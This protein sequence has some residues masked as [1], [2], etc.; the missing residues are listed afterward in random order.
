MDTDRI[1]PN[2]DEEVQAA[3]IRRVAP[4]AP[5][6]RVTGDNLPEVPVF[7]A[8]GAGSAIELAQL[9]PLFSVPAPQEYLDRSD[10]AILVEGHSMEPL[11]PHGAVVG[12]KLNVP[13]E[14]GHLYAARIPYE[15]LLVKRIDIDKKAGEFIFS[16]ENPDKDAY[17][18]FRM[19]I[20]ESGISLVGRVTWVMWGY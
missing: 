14:P 11:V 18:D 4:Y 13:Y 15:G 20:E 2:P 17:P 3:Y 12:I 8:A 16:S 19:A 7:N 5:V 1:L 10:F 6:E 9:E